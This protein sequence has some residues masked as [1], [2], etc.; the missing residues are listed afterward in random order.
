MKKILI[1]S[2]VANLVFTVLLI[3]GCPSR[4]GGGQDETRNGFKA[5]AMSYVESNP[6]RP[7]KVVYEFT[8]G[9]DEDGSEAFARITFEGPR[10]E[11]GFVMRSY[12]RV[13]NWTND[14]KDVSFTTPELDIVVN[15]FKKLTKDN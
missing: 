5:S 15:D 9:K 13:I 6:L 14:E 2:L 1:I 4:S 8:V 10:T 12:P 11:Y 3:Q 7:K